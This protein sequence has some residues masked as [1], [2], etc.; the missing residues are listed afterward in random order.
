M[1][2]QHDVDELLEDVLAVLEEAGARV[3][4]PKV[5]SFPG[6]RQGEPAA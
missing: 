6:G 2:A 5:V 1:E 4:A 3:P